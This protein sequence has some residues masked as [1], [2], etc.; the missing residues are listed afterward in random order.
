MPRTIR[1]YFDFASPYSYLAS[2]Q[3]KALAERADAGLEYVP[4]SVLEV[5]K[6]VDNTPTTIISKVKGAY[7]MAD[8]GRWVR[9]YQIP[10]STDRAQRKIDNARLLAGAAIAAEAGEGGA[11]ADAVFQGVWG[12]G[13]ALADDAVLGDVLRK[14]GLSSVDSV[15]AGRER[16]AAIIAANVTAAAE[17]GVFGAPSFIVGGQLYFGN[18][19][20]G[21]LEEALAA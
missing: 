20:L 8:I 3:L 9:R 7:A 15:L 16:G 10:F 12:A 18:D 5:M 17:A 2:T 14:A 11:Y 13:P 4:I 21:F 19:R 1:F 6:L